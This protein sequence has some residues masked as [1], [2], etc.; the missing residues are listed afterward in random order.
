MV[1]ITWSC[2]TVRWYLGLHL[3]RWP[4]RAEEQFLWSELLKD[5]DPARRIWEDPR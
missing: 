4:R 1:A 2:P 3:P 5:C